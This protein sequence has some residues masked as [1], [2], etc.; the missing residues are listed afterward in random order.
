MC[1]SGRRV[2]H[3]DVWEGL[4]HRSEEAGDRR[5]VGTRNSELRTR[6]ISDHTLKIKIRQ[7]ISR[8]KLYGE[9]V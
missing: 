9:S 8:E 2:R 7:R 1:E 4:D 6:D 5:P 3:A